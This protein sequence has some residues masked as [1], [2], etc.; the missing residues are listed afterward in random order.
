MDNLLENFNWEYEYC[1]M[2]GAFMIAMVN[3][4]MPK[5]IAACDID[6]WKYYYEY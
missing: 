5:S 4:N 1:V 6:I 3:W 2:E